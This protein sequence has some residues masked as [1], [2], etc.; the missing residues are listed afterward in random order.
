MGL[1]INYKTNEEI[2][3]IR[4]SSLLVSK[5]LAEVAKYIHPGVTTLKLDNIA[6]EFINANN[7][8]A[9]F[10]GYKNFPNSLCISVNE[11]VVHGIPGNRELKEGD[12]VSIDCGVLKD[13]WFGDSAYTFTVG[14]VKEEILKLLQVTKESLYKGIENAV[15]GKRLGDI[16]YAIQEYNH[17]HGYSIVREMVGHGVGKKLHEEPEVPNYGKKGNGILLKEGLVLAIEPMINMGKKEVK[18]SSDKWTIF[19]ADRMPSAHF[20]HTVAVKKEKA[21]VL[22]TFEYIEEALAKNKEL[23]SG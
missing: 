3:L 7:A 19:T 4:K 12:I 8:K 15:V 22:S 17:S 11:E 13:G 10:K 18:Q 5:T 23:I 14:E 9:A 16:C 6:E 20:E 21:D 2:E 1:M